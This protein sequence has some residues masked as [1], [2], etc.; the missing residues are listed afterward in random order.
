MVANTDV[1]EKLRRNGISTLSNSLRIKTAVRK[2]LSLT[3]SPNRE[4]KQ[5]G[6][7]DL[8]SDIIENEI[9]SAI[10][11][12]KYNKANGPNLVIE[13]ML[14]SSVQVLIPYLVHYFNIIFSTGKLHASWS[15]SV[16]VS[17]HKSC[18]LTNPDNFHDFLLTS[19][20][21]SVFAHILK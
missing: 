18:C 13:E 15:K 16:V 1:A 21:S 4:P 7:S 19:I 5:F 6:V 11:K 8:N 10:T 3:G 12:L 2:M 14:K 9:I 17:M 20:F